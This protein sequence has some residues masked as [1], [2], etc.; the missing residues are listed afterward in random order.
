[1]LLD[2]K[3]IH[4]LK[5]QLAVQLIH[6]GMIFEHRHDID[7]ARQEYLNASYFDPFSYDAYFLLVQ[8]TRSYHIKQ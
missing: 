3:S 1:M 8:K 2:K 7:K 6:R 5:K 4:V